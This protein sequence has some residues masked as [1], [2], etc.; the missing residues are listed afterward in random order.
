MGG[1]S[2]LRGLLVTSDDPRGCSHVCSDQVSRSSE[3][4]ISHFPEM[5]RKFQ[6]KN[7]REAENRKDEDKAI[8][9]YR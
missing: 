7:K 1:P 3:H 2:Q 8:V 5:S 9:L 6:N 4:M